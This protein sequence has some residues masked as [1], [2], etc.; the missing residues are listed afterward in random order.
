MRRRFDTESS[1]RSSMYTLL[2][3]PYLIP[4][5]LTI[6]PAV[7]VMIDQIPIRVGQKGVTVLSCSDIF[8]RSF[9]FSSLLY[10]S[11]YHAFLYR[12]TD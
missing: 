6:H 5:F 9:L 12:L 10:S 8:Y 1:I 7:A 4:S 2:T 11:I 3:L